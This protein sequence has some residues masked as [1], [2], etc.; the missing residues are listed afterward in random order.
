VRLVAED[1]VAYLVA[2]EEQRAT[3]PARRGGA[4]QLTDLIALVRHAITPAAPLTPFAATVEE[5]YRA[6]LAEQEGQG[7]A[8][9]PEQRGWLD[10]IRDHIAASLRIESDDFDYI[11][12]SER[13][14]L[15]RVYSLFG[16]RLPVILAELNER[17][18]A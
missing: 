13:G 16:E 6:W 3:A 9:T 12:F 8:F 2:Q 14:G 11:P 17:L 4:R 18:I 5:R 7:V 1:R 15:G 10:T